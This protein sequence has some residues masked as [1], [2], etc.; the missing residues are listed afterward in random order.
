MFTVNLDKDGFILSISHTAFDNVSLN[1]EEMDLNHLNA[2]QL[3]DGKAVL[4]EEKLAELVAEEEEREK[5]IEIADLTLQLESSNDDMLGFLEDLGSLTNP[6]TFISD[7]ISLA[8]KY[9]TMIANRKSIREQIEELKKK[10]KASEKSVSEVHPPAPKQKE[11]EETL[12]PQEIFP[13]QHFT[14]DQ[15]FIIIHRTLLTPA[16]IS[17]VSTGNISYSILLFNHKYD[18][19]AIC[20]LMFA[21]KIFL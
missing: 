16:E 19:D 9:A 17:V 3:I 13:S 5:E 6:L 4:N 15:F 20:K 1:L 2:Y 14:R 7:L 11:E 18:K 8:K 12:F 21:G 10:L